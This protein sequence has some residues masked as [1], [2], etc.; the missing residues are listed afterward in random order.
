MLV[1]TGG[2]GDEPPSVAGPGACS[3]NVCYPQ[4]SRGDPSHLLISWYHISC[5]RSQPHA[6]AR[7]PVLL[8]RRA[9]TPVSPASEACWGAEGAQGLMGEPARNQGLGAHRCLPG[10]REDHQLG[11]FLPR[12]HFLSFEAGCMPNAGP[13]TC[14]TSLRSRPESRGVWATRRLSIC[15][16]LRS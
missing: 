6:G 3:H 11:Q 14:S 9:C 8:L 5:S 12:E 1:S 4:C 2:G 13:S 10:S 7:L 15:L 16:W